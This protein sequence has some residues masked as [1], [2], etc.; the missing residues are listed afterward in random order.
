MRIV[1]LCENT[2]RDEEIIAE[3][4]LSLYIETDSH[5]ILFDMGQT[6]AFYQNAKKLKVDLSE[7]DIAILSHG[8]YDHGGGLAKFLEVNDKAR[9]YMNRHAFGAHYNGTEKFIGLDK[10]M[11]DCERVC[12]VDES[13][14][15]DKDVELISCNERKLKYPIIPYGLLIKT[16]AGFAPERFMHEH[17]LV[18]AEAGKRIV[19]SGCSHK[20]ILNIMDWLRPD[21]LIGGFHF[22]K[23]DVE[24]GGAQVLQDAATELLSYKTRYYTGHCTGEKQYE[25]LKG[26]MGEHVEYIYAGCELDLSVHL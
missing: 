15:L 5:K 19:V 2:T 4:G 10:T 7:V 26:Y 24:N 9:I 18:L 25:F 23:L 11:M 21:V 3:H 12:F 17:Y 16:E 13:L 1:V 8:H 6:D 20:G 22:M 14:Q